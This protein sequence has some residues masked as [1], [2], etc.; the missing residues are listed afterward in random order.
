MP[1]TE[2]GLDQCQKEG[3][4]LCRREAE[5]LGGPV[6]RSLQSFPGWADGQDTLIWYS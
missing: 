3:S 4:V 5:R 1:G 2:T 6:S